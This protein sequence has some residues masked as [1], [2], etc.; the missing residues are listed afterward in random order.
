MLTLK[1]QMIT[2]VLSGSSTHLHFFFFG[3]SSFKAD[4]LTKYSGNT[5]A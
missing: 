2:R 3:S 4:M 5:Y 1:F